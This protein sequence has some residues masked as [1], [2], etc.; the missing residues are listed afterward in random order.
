K[1]VLAKRGANE[2]PDRA[3]II[4]HQN[5]GA[6]VGVWLEFEPSCTG[7]RRGKKYPERAAGTRHALHKNAALLRAQNAGDCSQSQAPSREL[8]CEEWIKDLAFR[9]FAD[10]APRI[11]D[12]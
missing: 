8:G 9:I 12:L 11:A 10:T 4:G 5:C 2:I 3:L 7:F 6:H 1:A